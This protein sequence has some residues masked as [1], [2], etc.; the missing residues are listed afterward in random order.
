MDAS[1]VCPTVCTAPFPPTIGL[2]APAKCLLPHGSLHR[3]LRQSRGPWCPLCGLSRNGGGRYCKECAAQYAR[4]HRRRYA[5]LSP[6]ER[7]QDIARSYVAVYLKRG[8]IQK[9]P[10]IACDAPAEET[11]AHHHNGYDWPLDVIWVCKP[12]HQDLHAGRTMERP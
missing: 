4:G 1:P 3:P 10:C 9:G 5:D 12:C 11:Q 2:P 7:Q 8:H 6:F